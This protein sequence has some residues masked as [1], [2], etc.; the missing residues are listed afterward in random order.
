[1]SGVGADK[2]AES[3]PKGDEAKP[4][5]PREAKIVSKEEK[6]EFRDQNGNLLNAEQVKELEGKVEFKTKYETRTRV[7][8]DQGNEVPA[9]EGGWPG[10]AG[11]AA[12]VAPP[13]P[14]VEG[15]DKETVRVDDKP[16]QDAAASRDGEK[17]SEWS[18]AKPASEGQ[19][20]TGR[21]E[22]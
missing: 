9:P 14:D 1:M 5:P 11:G 21:D 4:S 12:G 13:H 20:A 17:E 16:P 22:L 2:T 3:K 7:V 8:D 10:D 19:E 6:V 18:K 15:V